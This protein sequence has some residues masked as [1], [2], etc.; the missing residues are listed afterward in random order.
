MDNIDAQFAKHYKLDGRKHCD[1]DTI[2]GGRPGIKVMR[3][4]L[5]IVEVHGQD[6]MQNGL[7]MVGGDVCYGK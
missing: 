6:V 5:G 2:F 1:Y 4:G 3:G 7:G